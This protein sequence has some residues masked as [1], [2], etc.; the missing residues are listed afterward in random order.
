M[1]KNLRWALEIYKKVMAS[2]DISFNPILARVLE[3]DGSKEMALEYLRSADNDL[4]SAAE[5]W[6]RNMAM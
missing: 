6:A 4:I 3:V 2:K 5:R 1:Q